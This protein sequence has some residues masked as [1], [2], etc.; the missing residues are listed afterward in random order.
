MSSVSSLSSSLLMW[1]QPILSPTWRIYYHVLLLLLGRFFVWKSCER[2]DDIIMTNEYNGMFG[3]VSSPPPSSWVLFT[4]NIFS[5]FGF[6]SVWKTGLNSD[7]PK[8]KLGLT[9]III[10][11]SVS[12]SNRRFWAKAG[13]SRLDVCNTLYWWKWTSTN[14]FANKF[15]RECAR[16]WE[17]KSPFLRLGRKWYSQRAWMIHLYK[18][19]SDVESISVEW[20]WKLPGIFWSFLFNRDIKWEEIFS[21]PDSQVLCKSHS[22]NI[23][24]A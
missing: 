1:C 9:I 10:S 17:W 13:F 8:L 19:D 12:N 21:R 18:F 4:P 24:F 15:W 23:I 16:E 22:R 7:R 3:L 20:S 2:C 11:L 5:N 14:I 6:F